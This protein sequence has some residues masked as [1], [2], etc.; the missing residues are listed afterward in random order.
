MSDSL[1]SSLH[2]LE[3]E[4]KP[5]DDPRKTV[6]EL[7]QRCKILQ[8]EVEK[9]VSAVDA[10]Q[11]DA[12]IPYQVEYRSL[13]NDFKNEL[14]F[15]SKLQGSD[16]STEKARHYIV[17]S[18]LLYYEAL[19]AAA[20]RSSG[21]LGF[22]KYFFWN[23]QKEGHG[24]KGLSLAKGSQTKGKSSALVDIVADDGM[25]WVR[26][27][28]I[29]EKRLLFDLAKLGWQND[30][31]SDEDTPDAPA[32]N[33][34]DDDDDDQVDIVKNA[35]ELARAARANPIRGHGPKV[36]FV[37]TRIQSGKLKEVD[38]VLDKIRET[39]VVVQCANE[40]PET[41]PLESVLPNLLIDRSRTLS[42]TLNIDC[43]ILLA[44]IS[45]ISH[46]QCPILDWVSCPQVLLRKPL[47]M[48]L[49]TFANVIPRVYSI[50]AKFE[51]RSRR[52]QTRNCYPPTSIRQSGRAQWCALRKRLIR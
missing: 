24:T 4:P 15:L 9:Y 1:T 25:E 26:V 8:E 43:T 29:S 39:G 31:D 32:S 52:K 35:R 23:R 7:I 51:R 22:R 34:E 42:S 14:A 33:W 44:L 5:S 46:K 45:D 21:L 27:S 3:L 30:S 36:L 17:S 47:A 38:A 6:V 41:L 2:D 12:K 11:K 50:L 28:T 37:L 40:I 16:L 20:K 49:D 19:W 18:N 48:T 13:R 10:N